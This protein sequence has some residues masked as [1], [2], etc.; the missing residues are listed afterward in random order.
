M[1][2]KSQSKLVKYSKI[3]VSD[4]QLYL[5]L[6]PI[7]VWYLLWMYKPMGGLLIAFK[8]YQPNL[9]VGGSDWVGFSNFISLIS[10]SFAEQF[11]RAF[12]NTFLISLY[13]LIFGFPI[14]II[15]ALF[16]SEISNK[17]YRNVA[18]TFTYLPHFLSEVTITGMVLTL[19]Y[20]GEVTTGV[21]AAFLMKTGLL[22]EGTKIIQDATYFRPVYIITGIWKE[23]GYS[24]IVYF[25]AIMGISPVLYEAIKVDGG[26]KLQEIKYVTFPGMAPTLIIM[27]ILR[28]GRML[29]VGYERIILLYNENTY[30]T[31][32][33]LNSFVYRIGLEGG[34]QAI[35]ASAGMF[36]A[37]IAFAL[38]MGAN[39]ISRQIS[40]TSLW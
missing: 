10:G 33:V 5:L 21:I 12:R 2:E 18:Q 1:E 23:A 31:A 35:G 27:I 7:L 20:N 39:F 38:V 37:L 8:N 19:L 11:W 14:P 30:Q 13:G 3:I 22:S 36:N 29:S 9:G 17:I 24:S 4:W 15:L 6:V 32:D 26:S 16:F 34:K 28:I 25:A 40:E